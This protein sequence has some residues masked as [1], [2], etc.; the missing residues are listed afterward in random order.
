MDDNEERKKWTE[1]ELR[2]LMAIMNRDLW[3]RWEEYLKRKAA[4]DGV[5]LS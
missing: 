1:I 5:Q 2:T 3:K 4:G